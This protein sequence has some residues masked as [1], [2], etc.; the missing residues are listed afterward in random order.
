MPAKT[1]IVRPRGLQSYRIEVDNE[2]LES[3]IEF[4]L[5]SAHSADDSCEYEEAAERRARAA[6]L[7]TL[8]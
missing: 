5:E 4:H 7:K 2:E 6:Y 3:I 8:L 1:K